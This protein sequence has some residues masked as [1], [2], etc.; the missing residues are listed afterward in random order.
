MINLTPMYIKIN[1]DWFMVYRRDYQ[2]AVEDAQIG[3]GS[4]IDWVQVTEWVEQH[5]R[6]VDVPDL[7]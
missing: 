5:G 1:Q 2:Q 6:I 4:N 3:N 7:L